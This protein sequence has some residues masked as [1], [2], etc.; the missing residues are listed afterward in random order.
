GG[1]LIVDGSFVIA[2]GSASGYVAR[3]T[4]PSADFDRDGSPGTARDIGA[5]FSCLAASCWPACGSAVFNW[6]GDFATD[7]DIDAFLRGLWAWEEKITQ[8]NF[9]EIKVG[10]EIFEVEKILGGKGSLESAGSSGSISWG[11]VMMTEVAAPNIYKWEHGTKI[12][13]VTAKDGKVVAKG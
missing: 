11:G 5:F 2:G 13:T 6:H 8:E 10:M 9:D 7:A 3:W 12:I 1:D 4:I